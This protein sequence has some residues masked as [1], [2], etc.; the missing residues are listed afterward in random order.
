MAKKASE[1]ILE[2]WT[3]DKTTNRFMQIIEYAKKED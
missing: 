2:N 1:T 3:W